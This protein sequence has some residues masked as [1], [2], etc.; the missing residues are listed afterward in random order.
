MKKFLCIASLLYLKQLNAQIINPGFE[1]W[2]NDAAVSS[3]MNPNNGNG[4]TGWWDYNVFNSSFVGSSPLSVFRCDTAHSGSYSARIQTVVYTATSW[5]IYKA[6]G[7]PYIGH[8]YYDT[9][10]IL[11]NGTVNETA[12]ASNPGFPFTQKI[13]RFSFYYQYKP[14]GVDTAECRVS[15]VKSGT[16]IA[17]G[18]FKTNVSTGSTWQQ[19]NVTMFYLDTLTP[20]TMYILF[21]ASSLDK[22][23]KP[24]SVLLVDDISTSLVTGIAQIK[25]WQEQLSVYPNPST[26]NFTV[27]TIANTKQVL[28]LFDVTGILVFSQIINGKTTLDVSSFTPGIYTLSLTENERIINKRIVIVK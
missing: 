16:L 10:G 18:I 14:N 11:Y 3:A 4:T 7:I 6:W 2:T 1:T 24:G 9:L 5:N 25:A 17:G 8:N 22:K 13:N 27:E 15:L 26:G 19:A 28:Q 20:D 23:P 21:S 12:A